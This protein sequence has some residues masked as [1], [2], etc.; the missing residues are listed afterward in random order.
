LLKVAPLLN[1]NQAQLK[2]YLQEY[3]LPD[4][5]DYFDPTK[6]HDARECGLQTRL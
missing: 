3:N 2:A 4:E 5:Q 1:W 6:V